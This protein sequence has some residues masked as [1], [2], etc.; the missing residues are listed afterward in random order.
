MSVR[1]PFLTAL[2]V[3]LLA[4]AGWAQKP[5]AY[6]D[7]ESG[8]VDFEIQGE[9]SGLLSGGYRRQKIGMQVVALGDGD[10][11]VVEFDGGLPGDGWDWQGRYESPAKRAGSVLA[12][13]NGRRMG[14]ISAGVLWL[15]DAEGTLQGLLQKK[16]RYSFTLGQ[17]APDDALVLFD[18]TST[19]HFDGGK[20]TPEGWLD[21]GCQTK[22]PVGDFQLHLEFRLPFMP[23]ATGQARGNSGCYI[24]E[25]Y[26]VQILDSFGLAGAFNE[27]GALYRQKP[28]IINMCLPPLSWQTYD[29]DFQGARFNPAGDKIENARITVRHN[30]V[31]VQYNYEIT[32]KTGAGKPEGPEPRPI[33][34]QNHGNPVVFR[35]IWIITKDSVP[36]TESEELPPLEV[37]SVSLPQQHRSALPFLSLPGNMNLQGTR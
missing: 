9:Y 34:L 27:C 28:P 13:D 24:Q 21:M 1:I 19:E 15:R 10:F 37:R 22:M 35:N 14:L 11:Q 5:A 30:G 3:S 33:K 17:Q 23:D 31:P 32:A 29:I 18:G 8:G 7:A 16:K 6:T 25:R 36:Q 20:I 26:E 2:V 12:F 4:T